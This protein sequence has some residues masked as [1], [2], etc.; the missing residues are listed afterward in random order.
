[1]SSS[2][3][4]QIC[5]DDESIIDTPMPKCKYPEGKQHR[6]SVCS[7]CYSKVKTMPCPQCGPEPEEKKQVIAPQS[8]AA[9]ATAVKPSVTTAKS[10]AAKKTPPSVPIV[11]SLEE[12]GKEKIL[13]KIKNASQCFLCSNDESNSTIIT[14]TVKSCFT[15][16]HDI[17]CCQDCIDKLVSIQCPVCTCMKIEAKK[18]Q[19]LMIF[20]EDIVLVGM[21]RSNIEKSLDW[22]LVGSVEAVSGLDFLE[23]PEQGA[24]VGLEYHPYHGMY[25]GGYIQT[26]QEQKEKYSSELVVPHWMKH[27]I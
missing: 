7:G 18:N 17:P 1:M 13:E 21:V 20:H 12:I 8:K 9:A 4:C 14:M 23:F 15:R 27:L 25:I 11:Q 24:C 5:N 6:I 2:Q 22:T 3:H 19:H 26:I 10:E 16:D